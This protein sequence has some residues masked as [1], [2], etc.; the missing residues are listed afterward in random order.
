MPYRRKL[1]EFALPLD[2]INKES[3][4]ARPIRHGTLHRRCERTAQP[5]HIYFNQETRFDT[6]GHSC[7]KLIT[8]PLSLRAQGARR[9]CAA[10]AFLTFG[11]SPRSSSARVLQESR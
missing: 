8:S 7:Y 4:R 5:I 2:A 3:A 11:Q 10:S 1:I 6:N 9:P